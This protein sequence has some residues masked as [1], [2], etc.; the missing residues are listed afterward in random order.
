MIRILSVGCDPHLMAVRTMVL[1]EAGYQVDE[2]NSRGEATRRLRSAKFH[3]V[4]ICHTI[5]EPEKDKLVTAARRL[6]PG[7]P[8][9]CISSYGYSSPDDHCETV[10]NVAPAFLTDLST[11]LRRTGARRI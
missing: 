6:Q 3:L 7:L 10:N 8:V 9:V 11:V 1:H 4:L 5:P 2:A